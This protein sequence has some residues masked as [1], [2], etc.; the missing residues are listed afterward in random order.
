MGGERLAV[1]SVGLRGLSKCRVECGEERRGGRLTDSEA[2]EEE[3]RD[4]VR[5]EA[6]A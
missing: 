4:G 1:E 5:A 3:E 2:E 6:P